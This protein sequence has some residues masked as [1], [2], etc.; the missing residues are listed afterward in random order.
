M[1]VFNETL[2]MSADEWADF[3]RLT[4]APWKPRTREEFDAMCD[5]GAARHKADNTDGCGWIRA[6]GC[7]AMKFGPGGEMNFPADP[8]RLAYVKVFGTMPNDE[9]L[10]EF[11]N[12]PPLRPGLKSVD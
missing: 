3:Q 12:A 6:T 4:H 7:S 8:R 9:Q 1:M 5:L 2:S 11:E 10:R